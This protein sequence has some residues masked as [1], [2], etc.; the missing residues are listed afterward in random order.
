MHLFRRH[1]LT[2][3]IVLGPPTVSFYVLYIIGV[4]LDK[5]LGGVFRGEFIREGGI[6]GLGILS[7]VLIITFVGM[8]AS[9]IIGRRVVGMWESMLL[10]IPILNRV[11]NGA[12]QIAEA[13]FRR[14]SRT[15]RQ[16][17]LVEFP[18]KGIYSVGF[19]TGEPAGELRDKSGKDL[20]S[21]FLPTTP[22]P[23][24]GYLLLVP[25]DD[26]I[27]LDMTVEDGL[28]LTISAGS[29]IPPEPSTGSSPG[30]T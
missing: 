18:R 10:K 25:R 27:T 21:V 8:L 23:T 3:L 6:P 5:V 13:L 4:K 7:L 14:E 22:N 1:F 24:S 15:F 11:Y 28:K 29:V 16:V 17:V 20:I 9:N 2:G 30:N 12:K 26:A 19:L